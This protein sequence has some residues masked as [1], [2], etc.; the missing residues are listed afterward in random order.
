MKIIAILF[1]CALT[2]PIR[3]YAFTYDAGSSQFPS[4]NEEAGEVRPID[5]KTGKPK[6]PT[7]LQVYKKNVDEKFSFGMA[8]FLTGWTEIISEPLE[9][10]SK[11]SGKKNRSLA[12]MS[13]FG[14]GL[15]NGSLDTIGGAVTILTSPVPRLKIPLPENGVDLEKMTGSTL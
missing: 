1:F 12:F 15:L 7:R 14:A 6:L 13:G 3:G 11:E 4:K 5:P 8:N 9:H 10:T 2:L